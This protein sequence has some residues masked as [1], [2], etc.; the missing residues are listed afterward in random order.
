MGKWQKKQENITHKRAKILTLSKV[1]TR[2]QWT[3]KTAWQTRN[4]NNKK[5][6]QKKHRLYFFLLEGL[7]KFYGTNLTLRSDVDQDK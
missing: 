7:N 3:E 5:N 1:T 4:T 2:L 6:P